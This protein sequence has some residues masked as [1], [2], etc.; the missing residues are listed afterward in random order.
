MVWNMYY[1]IT[2]APFVSASCFL[3]LMTQT[4]SHFQKMVMEWFNTKKRRWI[5]TPATLQ[6][7]VSPALSCPYCDLY[8]HPLLLP[9]ALPPSIASR[10]STAE[11]C[12]PSESKY[13]KHTSPLLQRHFHLESYMGNTISTDHLF[14]QLPHVAQIHVS[15]TQDTW[16]FSLCLSTTKYPVPSFR[17]AT[18]VD[19][20]VSLDT[21]H[22][23]S[24]FST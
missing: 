16:E 3:F 7:N 22:G 2:L 13:C 12:N 8:H 19:A 24:R 14:I 18:N 17:Y 23:V 11:S 15:Q 21:R 4:H 20:C 10:S 6:S 1:S 9:I 5:P